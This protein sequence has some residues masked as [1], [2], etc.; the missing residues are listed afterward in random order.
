MTRENYDEDKKL[1][2]LRFLL[3]FLKTVRVFDNSYIQYESIGDKDKNLSIKEYID[4]VRSYLI[5][6]I[7]KRKENRKFITQ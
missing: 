6:I 1:R 2:D 7:K 3:D 4:I 5:D